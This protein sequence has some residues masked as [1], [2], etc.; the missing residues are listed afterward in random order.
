M[1]EPAIAAAVMVKLAPGDDQGEHKLVTIETDDGE[2][3]D[4][5]FNC[6][7]LWESVKDDWPGWEVAYVANQAANDLATE[8]RLWQMGMSED[9]HVMP[10]RIQTY[11]EEVEARRAR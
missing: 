1:A 11:N 4:P 7:L 10:A 2:G 5:R 3:M 9:G 8:R 6:E